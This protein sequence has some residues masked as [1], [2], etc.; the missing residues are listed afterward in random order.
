MS[1]A[2]LYQYFKDEGITPM[3]VAKKTGYQY[4]YIIAI[5]NGR[6]ELSDSARLRICRAYPNTAHFLVPELYQ[7]GGAE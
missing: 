5:L 7:V 4:N 3:E 1:A 6:R 2:Q